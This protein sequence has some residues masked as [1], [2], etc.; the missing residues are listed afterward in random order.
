MEKLTY[1]T[2]NYGKYISVK[3]KF[4]NAG[5]TIDYFK[6]D[7]EEPNVNDIKFISKEKA[8]QAYEKIGSPVFVTDSGFFIENY[9]NNPGYPGAFV[10]RSGISSDIEKLLET[11]KGVS[12]RSCYFL[13]CLTFFDGNEYYQFWGISKGTLSS[14]VKGNENKKAMVCLCSK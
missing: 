12:N 4:E 9:P 11:M 3:E 6:C 13:D 7:L 5:I 8:R 2:G 1:I 10:K 14:E